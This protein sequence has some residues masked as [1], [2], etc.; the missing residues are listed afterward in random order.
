MWAESWFVRSLDAPD[1][2]RLGPGLL[3]HNRQPIIGH[4]SRRDSGDFSMV[5]G[6]GNLDQIH[7]NQ[8]QRFK[9]AD[10]F[11]PLPAG[12]PPNHRRAGTGGKGRVQPVNIKRQ[13]D[14]RITGPLTH[15]VQR[16]INAMTMHPGAGQNFKPV[17]TVIIGAQPDL[18]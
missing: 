2:H 15:H 5:I 3:C 8:I 9:S 11:Q 4:T 7:P 6:R 10:E 1:R 14:R 12:Q 17:I 13:I 18:C 16:G